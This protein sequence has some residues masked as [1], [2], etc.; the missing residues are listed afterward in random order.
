MQAASWVEPVTP[1]HKVGAVAHSTMAG[2]CHVED[3]L[4]AK[5]QATKS[6]GTADL[7]ILG[8]VRTDGEV[9]TVDD[10]GEVAL[11]LRGYPA[12]SYYT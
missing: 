7:V 5:G 2:F 4:R 9:D 3:D 6:E 1:E 11:S 8:R 12:H 10:E